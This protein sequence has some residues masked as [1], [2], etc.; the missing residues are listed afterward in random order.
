ML[1][2]QGSGAPMFDAQDEPEGP[3]L[4]AADQPNRAQRKN[5]WRQDA[6]FELEDLADLYG[7]DVS[8][9]QLG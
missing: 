5:S 8:G 9:V 4:R 3:R 2:P 7:V 6:I 1:L